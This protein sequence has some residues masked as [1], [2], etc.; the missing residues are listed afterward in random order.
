LV[1]LLWFGLAGCAAPSQIPAGALQRHTIAI[2]GHSLTLWAREIP[3]AR[4]SILLL[5][6]RTW[7]ARPNFDLQVPDDQRSVMVALNRAGLNAFALD[8]RG[9]GATPRDGTGWLTPDRAVAD[10]AEVL[11]W[12]GERSTTPDRPALLGWS[13]GSLVAQLAAQRHPALLSDLVLFGYPRDP[14]SASPPTLADAVPLEELNTRE[15]ALSDFISPAVTPPPVVEAY[16]QAAL[17]TDP[18]RVDWR[19]LD[20]FNELDA[21]R[22]TVPTLL[23]HGERDPLTT[24]ENQSRL[25]VRLGTPDRR[26]VILAGGDHAALI[27]NTLPAFVDAIV[28]FIGRPR[29]PPALAAEAGPSK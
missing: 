1:V 9:Y 19:D 5:H 3:H 15:R 13:M 16:V 4:R 12:I 20:Q 23:L 29:L 7:S 26:W 24:L 11:R 18:V 8:L 25:F 10:V 14:A 2:E 28:G 6:G 22:V 21:A 17:A 27:E